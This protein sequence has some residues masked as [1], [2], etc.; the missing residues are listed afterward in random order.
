MA[1]VLGRSLL[2]RCTTAPVTQSWWR[3]LH[4]GASVMKPSLLSS[5]TTTARAA[6][7]NLNARALHSA[8]RAPSNGLLE[9]TGHYH[10][11]IKP[12]IV[13]SIHSTAS[14]PVRHFHTTLP[15]RFQSSNQLSAEDSSNNKMANTRVFFD[16]TANDKPVGRIVM[17][18]S[19]ISI[20]PFDR[21]AWI[22]TP[23]SI[24]AWPWLLPPLLDIGFLL[25]PE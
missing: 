19:L 21:C 23:S 25:V 11:T 12:T 5:A 14:N 13:E 24:T 17:E 9:H 22:L 6:Q 8:T 4:S 7:S 1:A 18:V 2:S 15:S 20:L 3:T 16:M 10:R